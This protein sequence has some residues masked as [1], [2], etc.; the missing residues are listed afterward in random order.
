MALSGRERM[1]VIGT[2]LAALV[3]VGDRY[4]LTPYAEA[5]DQVRAELDT[6]SARLLEGQNRLAKA[7][8]ME[9]DWR[10]MEAGGLKKDQSSAQFQ[11]L[12]AVANWARDA[13]VNLTSR[14]PQPETRNDRTQILRLHANGTC[15]TASAAK[16][17]WRVETASIPVKIDELT[18]SA[19]KPG[20]DDLAIIL[21]VS[22]IWVRPAEAADA[23]SAG[24][25]AAPTRQPS[26]RE[27]GI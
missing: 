26:G 12:D 5:R 23:K 20:T 9:R 16:L 13:G 14:T 21:V 3:F 22:T 24:G 4:A 18:L 19:R 2:G 1:I 27:E 25:A 17:L 6:T 15:T 8:R 10:N 11:L 7:R